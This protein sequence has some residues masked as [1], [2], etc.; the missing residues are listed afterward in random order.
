MKQNIEQTVEVGVL[1]SGQLRYEKQILIL[2]YGENF[3]KTNV[4]ALMV[5]LCKNENKEDQFSEGKNDNLLVAQPQHNA[6]FY[7]F[8]YQL[9]FGCF[10]KNKNEN[11]QKFRFFCRLL[12]C[13]P[14]SSSFSFL[15]F[16]YYSCHGVAVDHE[17]K[18]SP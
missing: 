16:F 14:L 15:S 3:K 9:N 12:F 7:N 6:I 5:L 11:K 4:N 2:K 18:Y 13:F 8:S 10:Q 1:Q 17:Q